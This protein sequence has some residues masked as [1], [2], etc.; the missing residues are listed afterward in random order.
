MIRSLRATLGA[1]LLLAAPLAAQPTASL[2]SGFTFVDWLSTGRTQTVGIGTVDT[3]NIVYFVKER[4]VGSLQSWYLFFDPSSTQSVR[5]SITFDNAID[6]LITTTSA[7]QSS[8]ATWGLASGITYGY[9]T[10]TG[11]EA[12]Q[13]DASFAGNVLS[14]DFTASD[15]GDHIRV[16]TLAADPAQVP[17]PSTLALLALG[18]MLVSARRRV[19]QA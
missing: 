9:V 18:A 12:A 3:R 4:Q 16:I 11:L 13:D 8:E 14:F 2:P 1:A 6:Q 15:P 10:A 5:G 19:R 7:L 17:E